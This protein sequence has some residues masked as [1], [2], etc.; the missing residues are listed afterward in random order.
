MRL[1]EVPCSNSYSEG[2][3][4]KTNLSCN[5]IILNGKERAN[6]YHP[7]RHQNNEIISPERKVIGFITMNL[8][9]RILTPDGKETNYRIGGPAGNEVMYCRNQARRYSERKIR[10]LTG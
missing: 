3:G 4:M 7:G 1:F 10:R 9:K 5:E 8:S 6:E 2:K